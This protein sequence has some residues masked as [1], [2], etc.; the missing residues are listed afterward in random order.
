MPAA[1]C[2]STAC[3]AAPAGADGSCSCAP[4]CLLRKVVLAMQS[5][6]DP[7][8]SLPAVQG[9]VALAEPQQ[10]SAP[11][12]CRAKSHQQCLQRRLQ[13]CCC[14]CCCCCC[15][16]GGGGIAARLHRQVTCRVKILK[17]SQV[18]N[19]LNVTDR[20]S[21]PCCGTCNQ[22][23]CLAEACK[24]SSSSLQDWLTPLH[25]PPTHISR[26]HEMYAVQNYSSKA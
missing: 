3:W 26:V 9:Q 13:A 23:C 11:I 18:S 17:Q 19:E 22:T 5:Q 7:L 24:V 6:T 20:H 8:P 21:L 1:A 4:T 2:H 15:C 12:T 16:G 10:P 25:Q 14:C